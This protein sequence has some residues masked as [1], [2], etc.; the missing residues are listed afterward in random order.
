MLIISDSIWNEIK[1]LIPEKKSKVGRPQND[2]K[3]TLSAILYIMTTGAQ[4]HQLPDYYGRPTTVHG[5]FRDWVKLGIFNQIFFKSIAVAVQHLGCRNHFLTIR[6]QLKLLLQNLAVKILQ[7]EQN[8]V[9]K[10]A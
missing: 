8:M 10:K 4:W 5:R 9:L 7:I 3:T 6:P 1:N 2:Q